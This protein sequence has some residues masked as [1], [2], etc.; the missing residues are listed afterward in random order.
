MKLTNPNTNSVF[1]HP[2]TPE[3]HCVKRVLIRS[4]SGPY[5]PQFG[6]NTEKYGVSLRIQSNAGKYGQ[7]SFQYG[8][9]WSQFAN[10]K[11]KLLARLI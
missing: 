4:F 8:Q 3:I 1:Q 11:D 2:I 6:L 7:K 10:T 5:F 9:F